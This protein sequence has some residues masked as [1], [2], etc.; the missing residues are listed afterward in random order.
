MKKFTVGLVV[1]T[2]FSAVTTFILSFIIL[3]YFIKSPYSLIVAGCTS[4]LF[5]L[6][7]FKT[8]YRKVDKKRVSIKQSKECKS[9]INQLCFDTKT[10]V[11][12]RLERA[13]KK[14]NFTVERKKGGLFLPE[15]NAILFLKFEFEEV[16]KTDV[17]KAF[18]AINL[19]EKAVILCPEFSPEIEK[20]A[21]RFDGKII[22]ISGYKVYKLLKDKDELPQIKCEFFS[23]TPK[24]ASLKNLFVKKRAKSFFAFGIV[25]LFMSLFSPIRIYYVI[26]G[27][28]MLIFAVVSILYG[29]PDKSAN[30]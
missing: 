22:L 9:V 16:K 8:L 7:V 1:D 29:K 28:T 19:K 20:F 12:S 2:I 26:S 11:L 13:L 6:F 21:E 27:C 14:S 10:Q 15:K 5:S 3:N 30:N 17:V 4:L 23:E 24:K 25:F 18:N